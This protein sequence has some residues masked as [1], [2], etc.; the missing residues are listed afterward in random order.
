MFIG[1][2]C[3]LVAPS[4][5]ADECAS[6]GPVADS[7][8]P[9][10][11]SEAPANTHF[12]VL[13]APGCGGVENGPEH[14]LRL[15]DAR[16][17][18]VPTHREAWARWLRELVPDGELAAGVYELQV[19]RPVST[20]ALGEWERLA[21]VRV[22]AERDERV[23]AFAGIESGTATVERGSV[24]IS[25]C[26]AR[27]GDVLRS[28]LEFTAADDAPRD[29]DELLYRLD[30]RHPGDASWEEW[31]TFRP[32]PDGQK[33]FFSW[34]TWESEEWGA[35]WEYRIAVRDI[36][37]HETVGTKTATVTAPR[38]PGSEPQ[39]RE[40]APHG[41]SNPV[42]T[43]DDDA[44]GAEPEEATSAAGSG[45]TG[46]MDTTRDGAAEAGAEPSR[47]GPQ[48]GCA[49]GAGATRPG[50][51]ILLM[52]VAVAAW[53]RERNWRRRQQARGERG[54]A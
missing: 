48:R 31:R 2:F 34:T 5:H 29:H 25:P 26:E 42:G 39:G 52:A 44:G 9:R 33:W 35:V 36:A 18:E 30:R 47:P 50:G 7:D 41:G 13:V 19:R 43:E 38:R 14:Q 49:V 16:G 6:N 53:G 27:E 28:R 46:T 4:T 24:P 51:A 23:P 11:G 10:D 22:T 8:V 1:G 15:I 20:E 21:R 45:T 12:R 37:G 54:A 3:F 40:A 17:A 32:T